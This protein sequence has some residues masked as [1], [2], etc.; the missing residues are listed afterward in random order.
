FFKELLVIFR[1]DL[2]KKFNS[3]NKALEERDLESARI[4]IHA[5]VGGSVNLS[6][7]ELTRQA[8]VMEDALKRK[9]INNL[10][11]EVEKMSKIIIKSDQLINEVISRL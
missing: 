10:N 5:V 6:L 8:R 11:L 3:F 1:K 9:E 4:Y 2:K 7:N